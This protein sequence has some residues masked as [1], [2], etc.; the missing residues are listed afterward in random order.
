M[1][2]HTLTLFGLLM[3]FSIHAQVRYQLTADDPDQVY[4]NF[5]AVGVGLDAGRDMALTFTTMGRYQVSNV[6][7]AESNIMIDMYKLNSL[8][9]TFLFDAGLFKPFGSQTKSKEVRV[10]TDFDFKTDYVKGE[11]TETTTF[12]T[13]PATVKVT[14]GARAGVYYRSSG[15]EPSSITLEE[16]KLFSTVAGVYIGGQ[17]TSRAFVNTKIEGVKGD[18]AASSFSR[19]YLDLMILPVS[20]INDPNIPSNAKADGF[21]GGRLGIQL[22][23]NAHKGHRRNIFTKAVYFT[24]VGYKPIQGLTFH[25]TY[26]LP[27]ISF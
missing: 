4:Q 10:I 8:G 27:L 15:L 19:V 14:K 9:S 21:L 13:V 18:R 22:Y 3:I 24:E 23:G 16:S 26:A 5:I 1:L 20:S 11:R 7:A 2:K 6:L 17:I 12:I 25:F